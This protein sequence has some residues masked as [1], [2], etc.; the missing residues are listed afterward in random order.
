[1][2]T[3][4][5]KAW[6][7]DGR[8]PK[9]SIEE[10]PMPSPRGSQVLV[11][12]M[13]ASVNPIDVKRA[14]GYGRRL[15]SLL[16]A[17]RLPLT[18]GNDFAGVIR[19]VGPE[20]GPWREGQ[21]VYG[22][23]PT[24]THGTHAQA[25]LADTRWL[26]AAPARQPLRELAVLPYSF[27]TMALTLRAARLDANTAA[28]KKV[29][30]NGAGGALGRLAL[31]TLTRWGAEV[32]A[33]CSTPDVQDCIALHAYRVVDRRQ[34]PLATVVGQF[35]ATLNYGSFGDESAMLDLLS[36][37]ALGH[38]TTVHPLLDHFDR[39]GW[40]GGL[41]ASACDFMRLRKQLRLRAQKAS[42]RWV[43]F[44][45]DGPA[46][47]LL[48]QMLERDAA[49]LPIGPAVPL[50]RAVSAYVHVRE[51]RYG[52]AVLLPGDR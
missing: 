43:I 8:Y 40:V 45:P 30:I 5:V 29:L 36:P 22:L 37:S 4:C 46:L 1:M 44:R 32:T 47:D 17:G 33:V 14:T 12:V 11:D 52:R 28:G 42:Y 6:T 13:A 7:A 38:A 27:T 48:Q 49:V 34:M 50:E 51:R 15:L 20:A 19:A 35:D 26:R 10:Q 24:G 3:L 25:L 9:L 23:Q 2:N 18:F 31:Q 39:L 41:R 21:R 16:G